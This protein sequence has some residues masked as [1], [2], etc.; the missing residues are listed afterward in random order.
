MSP[1][2]IDFNGL[3]SA[4]HGPVRLG[5]LTGLHMQ[6]R[7]NFTALKKLLDVSDGVLGVHLAKLEEIGYITGSTVLLGRRPQTTYRLTAQGKKALFT[8][9]QSMRKLLEAVESKRAGGFSD[10]RG[11]AGH[12]D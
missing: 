7:L 6:G 12:E 9:L 4:V 3:D 2:P 5:A 1:P 11:G 8:Y 10:H